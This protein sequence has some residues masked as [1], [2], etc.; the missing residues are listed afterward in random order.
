MGGAGEEG[1]GWCVRGGWVDGKDMGGVGGWVDE[2]G[3]G[4]V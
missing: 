3:V 1:C 2:R 4:C